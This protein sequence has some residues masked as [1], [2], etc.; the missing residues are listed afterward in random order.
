MTG[1]ADPIN[2]FAIEVHQ[3]LDW[4]SSGT[5]PHVISGAGRS[6]LVAF[7]EW[8][9]E[10]GLRAVLG[11]IG[12]ADNPRAHAEGEEALAYMSENRDVWIGFT[13]WAGGPWW[14]DYIFSIAPQDGEDRPQMKIIERYLR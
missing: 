4:D 7:T 12:W 6:R 1:V 9:R 13:Y 5:S 3:Y 14:G 10:N 2:N 11:E 8:A